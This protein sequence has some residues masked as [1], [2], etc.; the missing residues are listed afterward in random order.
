MS[1]NSALPRHY[2]THQHITLHYAT[3]LRLITELHT[4]FLSDPVYNENDWSFGDARATFEL[5]LTRAPPDIIS[6]TT[7]RRG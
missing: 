6:R 1:H 2:H 4:R 7:L 3:Q 5:L